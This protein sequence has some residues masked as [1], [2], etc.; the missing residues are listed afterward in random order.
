MFFKSV[1]KKVAGIKISRAEKKVLR[2]KKRLMMKI[3]L[4]EK[5]NELKRL[6]YEELLRKVTHSNEKYRY[7]SAVEIV[8]CGE[9]DSDEFYQIEISFII[10]DTAETGRNIHV[11]ASIGDGIRLGGMLPEFS[12]AFDIT[13]EGKIFE[14]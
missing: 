1:S 12:S 4:E 14:Y 13:E 5:M 11:T 10:V 3:A 8:E 9:L 7:N 2:D 6:S